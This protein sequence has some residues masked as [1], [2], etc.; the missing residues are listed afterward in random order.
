MHM[1]MSQS[2]KLVFSILIWLYLA[3]KLI[4]LHIDIRLGLIGDQVDIKSTGWSRRVFTAEAHNTNICMQ[5]LTKAHASHN[6]PYCDLRTHGKSVHPVVK[7][8]CIHTS[9][10]SP[11]TTESGTLEYGT[12]SLTA[13]HTSNSAHA[14]C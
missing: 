1:N 2:A 13:L 11:G 12:A 5:K 9:P 8:N 4:D 14:M 6:V 3:Y 7:H 10:C